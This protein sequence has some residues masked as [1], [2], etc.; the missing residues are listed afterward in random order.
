M[1]SIRYTSNVYKLINSIDVSKCIGLH[2]RTI[3]SSR[4][5][6]KSDQN[7]TK[8]EDDL[9]KYHRE[10]SNCQQFINQINYCLSKNPDATFFVCS[11]EKKSHKKINSNLWNKQNSHIES[12]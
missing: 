6:N 2:I 4:S 1:N 10:G 3:E 8:T 7:W 9:L 11:N 5:Y 12:N